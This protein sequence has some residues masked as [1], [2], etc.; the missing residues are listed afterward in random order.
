MPLILSAV[1]LLISPALSIASQPDPVNYDQCVLAA[2]NKAVGDLAAREAVSSCREKLPGKV[3]ED[4]NL[5]AEALGKLDTDGGFGYGIFSGSIYNGNSDYTVTQV[6]ILLTPIPA[7]SPLITREYNIDV[8]VQPLTKGA[9][10]VALISD[11]TREF[12]WSLT[13]ARGHKA[14]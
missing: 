5:T 8:T 1:A 7:G 2:T 9:L 13:K 14:R 12:S 3:P 4:E 6:T 10:S 11:G